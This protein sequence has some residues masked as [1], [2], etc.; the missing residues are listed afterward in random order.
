MVR[1]VLLIEIDLSATILTISISYKLHEIE[2]KL[3]D[4][5]NQQEI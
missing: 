5:T 2:G 4:R 3:G 1:L